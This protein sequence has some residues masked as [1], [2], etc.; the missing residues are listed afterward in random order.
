MSDA[1]GGLAR[2]VQ[3]SVA[4]FAGARPVASKRQRKCRDARPR[5]GVG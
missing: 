5:V 2:K 4:C 3:A 1:A